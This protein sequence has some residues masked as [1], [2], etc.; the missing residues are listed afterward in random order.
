MAKEKEA[1][2]ICLSRSPLLSSLH[3][4]TFVLEIPGLFF[5]KSLSKRP[6]LQLDLVTVLEATLTSRQPSE[7]LQCLYEILMSNNF[8]KA[9]SC[10][11]KI[12]INCKLKL[13]S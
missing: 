6:R 13:H 9:A 8:R 2:F 12:Y 4:I 10:S 1:L 5:L 11:E 7:K 3:V